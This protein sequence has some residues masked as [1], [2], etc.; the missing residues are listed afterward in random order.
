MVGRVATADGNLLSR[1]RVRCIQL[2]SQGV[3]ASFAALVSS[4]LLVL[5]SMDIQSLWVFCALLKPVGFTEPWEFVSHLSQ[6]KVWEQLGNSSTVHLMRSFVASFLHLFLRH[7]KLKF[8]P[9]GIKA[10][11]GV[12]MFVYTH[13]HVFHVYVH[14]KLC[15]HMCECTMPTILLITQSS[16]RSSA[17]AMDVKYGICL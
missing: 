2:D 8:C 5:R 13:K 14:L 11:R 4:S 1:L 10:H 9:L 12:C 6:W 15:V 7:S 16:E 3:F 17:N